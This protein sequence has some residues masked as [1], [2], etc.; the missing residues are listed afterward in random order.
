VLSASNGLFDSLRS[1]NKSLER[2]PAADDGVK[3]GVTLSDPCSADTFLAL[4]F[5][6]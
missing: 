3:G 1:V 4:A 2:T 6:G 5:A